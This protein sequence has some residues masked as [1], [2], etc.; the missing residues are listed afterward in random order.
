[1]WKVAELDS[2]GTYMVSNMGRIIGP[3]GKL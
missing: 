1:M 2:K 3:S